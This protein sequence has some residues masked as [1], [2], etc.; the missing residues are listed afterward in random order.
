MAK[1][2]A[3]LEP[4]KLLDLV[5]KAGESD[6]A[7]IDQQIADQEATLADFTKKAEGDISA[8]K[9]L[10]KVINI[11]LHGRPPRKPHVRKA[12][13]SNPPQDGPHAYR[14]PPSARPGLAVGPAVGSGGGAVDGTISSRVKNL[15]MLHGPLSVQA[16]SVKLAC[17]PQA[18]AMAVTKSPHSFKRLNDGRVA[19]SN[20][21]DSD[22]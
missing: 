8:L 5:A 6:L 17:S 7:E 2:A 1:A 13:G 15:L 19:P 14:Q 16:L 22:D 4:P 20:Y 11:K 21:D 9:A 18:I 3:T 12:K 10:R